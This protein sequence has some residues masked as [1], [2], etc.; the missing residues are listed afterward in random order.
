[1]WLAPTRKRPEEG[2]A[3]RGYAGKSGA[4][5]ENMVKLFISPK[6]IALTYMFALL[7]CFWEKFLGGFFQCRVEWGS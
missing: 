6:D 5:R 4:N 2:E 3:K 1:M 7:F